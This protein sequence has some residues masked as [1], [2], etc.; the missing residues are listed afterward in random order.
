MRRSPRIDRNTARKNEPADYVSINLGRFCCPP[1]RNIAIFLETR[2]SSLRATRSTFTARSCSRSP[3]TGT[4]RWGALKVSSVEQ[5]QKVLAVANKYKTPLWPISTG[6][7]CGYGSAAPATPGQFVLDLRGMNKIISVDPVLCTS[8]GRAGSHLSPAHRLHQR[9]EARHVGQLSRVGEDRRPRGKHAR[10][11]R[12]LQSQRRARR[13]LL[14]AWKWCWPTV[15]CSAP[16]SVTLG[17]EARG[18]RSAGALARGST[19]CSVSRIL[20]S[21]PRWACG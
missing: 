9:A 18:K 11:R 1:S 8:V 2:E 20:A 5:V 21:L 19:A 15:R 12:W 10:S 14:A 16:V 17:T 7:N 3:P 6:G 13:K 4:K